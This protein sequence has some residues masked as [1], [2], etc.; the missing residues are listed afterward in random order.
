MEQTVTVLCN[1][2]C[3]RKEHLGFLHAE[4]LDNILDLSSIKSEFI[5]CVMS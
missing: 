1:E 2:R 5:I 3:S 4:N